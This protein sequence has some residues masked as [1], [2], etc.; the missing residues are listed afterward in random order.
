[1]T[2]LLYTLALLYLCC[3]P[4]VDGIAWGRI[5]EKARE[6]LQPVQQQP[7][8]RNATR[9]YNLLEDLYYLDESVG[10]LW[11]TIKVGLVATTGV[12]L[13]LVVVPIWLILYRVHRAA[14]TL[15]LLIEETKKRQ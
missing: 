14:R 13:L 12:L 2:R 9:I 5:K 8:V 1:M 7:P 6:L 3:A 11:Q 15:S 4:S 10:E